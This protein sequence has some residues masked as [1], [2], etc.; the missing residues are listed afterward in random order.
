MEKNK[1]KIEVKL[2]ST[3]FPKLDH[4]IYEDNIQENIDNISE[5]KKESKSKDSLIEKI[6]PSEKKEEDKEPNEK[7]EKKEVSEE[8]DLPKKKGALKIV[9]LLKDFI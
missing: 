4:N 6:A 5:I 2:L 8:V 3:D 1:N 7:K 9:E